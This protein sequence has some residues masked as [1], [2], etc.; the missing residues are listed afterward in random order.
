M[1][2]RLPGNLDNRKGKSD[3][4]MLGYVLWIQK[5]HSYSWKVNSY[6]TS[7][8]EGTGYAILAIFKL[9]L[10][11]S[12][13][14]WH[15]VQVQIEA[16]QGLSFGE[17]SWSYPDLTTGPSPYHDHY[18]LHSEIP[19]PGRRRIICV[20]RPI[21]CQRCFIAHIGSIHSRGTTQRHQFFKH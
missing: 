12:W 21:T 10:S 2:L 13:L 9:P 1:H 3:R 14:A 16:W 17:T 20:S 19:R 7:G 15:L 4:L 5:S 6:C 8:T 18:D 11:L